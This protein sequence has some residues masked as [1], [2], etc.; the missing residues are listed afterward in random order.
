L[1]VAP[2]D[3]AV[4]AE[5]GGG[6]TAAPGPAGDLGRSDD[7]L[8]SILAS[9]ET[10]PLAL[11]GALALAAALGALHGLAPGHGKTAIGAFLVA[12][13]GTR[14]QAFALAL[15]V[16]VSHTLG[17]FV[18]GAVTV[19]ASSQFAPERAYP[20]LQALSGMIMLGLGIWIV[21]LVVQS[22]RS[23]PAVALSPR[24]VLVGA[25]GPALT[26]APQPHGDGH[27]RDHRH[28]HESSHDRDHGHGH[29]HGH[30]DGDGD[31]HGGGHDHDHDHGR[32]RG[33]WH[34]HG[35]LPHR[36]GGALRRLDPADGPLSTKALAAIGLSGGLVPS[37]A[38]VI[39][40]LGAI[41]LERLLTGG[42]LILAFG[43][44]MAVAL[45]GAGFGVVALSRR[46]GPRFD[47]Q[48]WAGWLTERARPAAGVALVGVGLYLTTRA[49]LA[50]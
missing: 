43:A 9:G 35:L 32:G 28:D 39:L 46:L 16:A 22:S 50:V 5:L 31:D 44:G 45:V 25:G 14:R 37:T 26:E 7:P 30:G 23:R 36:H 48:R 1:R 11:A 24:P 33:R 42:L 40:L 27:D 34:T 10:G 49:L 19:L 20:Y 4:A 41:Q 6:A 47:Q 2:G 38:A 12:T 21:A 15:A 18:L 3:S 13:R 29:G 8:L 17:V